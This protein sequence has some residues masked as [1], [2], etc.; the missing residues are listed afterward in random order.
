MLQR[1]DLISSFEVRTVSGQHFSYRDVWQRR[2]LVAIA[3][4]ADDPASD[5]YALALAARAAEFTT[6]QTEC[7]VTTDAVPGV[8]APGVLV[9]D[10]WGEVAHAATES[11]VDALPTVDALLEWVHYIESRCPECEGEAR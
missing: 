2:H 7:V 3:L 9:A 6:H 11:S 10:R 4:P 5:A 8:A 1:G